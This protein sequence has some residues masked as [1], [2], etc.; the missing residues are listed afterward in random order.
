MHISVLLE[1]TIKY[2]DLNSTD[3]VVDATIGLGGHSNKILN[4][5]N[6][7]Y[8]Y[9][10]D[11][12]INAVNY[13]NELLKNYKNFEIINTNFKNLKTELNNRNINKID[14]V[15]FDLG[16]SSPQLD[17]K[18]RGFSF[19][20][21]ARLDMRMDQSQSLDA[22]KVVNEY[23]LEDLI[24]IFRTYGEEKHS[25]SIAKGI[26]KNRPINTTLEL[27]E[28]IKENVPISYRNK[29]H[30]ARKIFQAIRIEVNDELNVFEQTLNDVLEMLN[31]GGRV[32][33]ISF[34]SLEDKIVKN[35]F[36]ELSS[37]PSELSKLP[38]VPEHL[39][40][41]YKIVCNIEP[42]NKELEENKRARSARLRVIERVK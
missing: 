34:H 4:V 10:F 38:I 18:E 13:S 36:K 30:P 20:E 11:Q 27:A 17:N 40:P 8:L 41:S 22:Y 37:L 3:I 33:V 9:G 25:V 7:G 5:I 2:L 35:K 16:V 29:K 42:S 23:S 19:H 15:L 26:I 32:A 12:D 28:I 24:K 21:D 6:S 14:K 39:K 1:E 31:I